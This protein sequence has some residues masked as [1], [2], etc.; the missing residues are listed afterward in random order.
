M[1]HTVVKQISDFK[2]PE[3][4]RAAVAIGWHVDGEAGPIGSDP[5]NANHLTARSMGQYGVSTAIPRILALHEELGIPA[6]FFIPGYVAE[7]NPDTI[8][9]I[10]RSGNEIAYHGY[11]HEN[12]FTRSEEEETQIFD[13]QASCMT[14]LLGKQ[15]AG[16]SA[17]GW[18]VREHTIQELCRL[19]VKYD[20][21]L[22]EFDRP[23]YLEC[24]DQHLVE[25]PI[26]IVLDDYEIMG[27]SL[28]PN[29]GGI[30]APAREAFEI[31]W[32]E[33]EG[34]R[35]YQGLYTTTFHPCILGRP[36]RLLMLKKLLHNM[37]AF[38]DIWFATY[39]QVADYVL[40]TYPIKKQTL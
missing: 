31:Y 13:R 36:G 17:P 32:E 18:G 22:M 25:L 35:H 38:N 1:G 30:N 14:K 5:D 8:A 37:K 23:Y 24:G 28:Y 16:W 6:S 11:M 9:L 4:Y 2:W 19:G 34:I 12:V 20:S 29:G 40:T 27:A 26:S 15:L 7:Q 33:F 3:P 21:S 39:E 10:N